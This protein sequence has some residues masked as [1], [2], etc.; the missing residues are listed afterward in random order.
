M[1]VQ[2]I[3]QNS[4]PT[5]RNKKITPRYGRVSLQITI[6][7]VS[8]ITVIPARLFK[9]VNID[10]KVN[11]SKPGSLPKPWSKCTEQPYSFEIGYVLYIISGHYHQSLLNCCILVTLTRANFLENHYCRNELSPLSLSLACIY[12]NKVITSFK[13]VIFFITYDTSIF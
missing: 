3:L 8:V 11:E 13:T 1:V 2:Q 4:Q 9:D 5:I 7:S 6:T 10:P 12:K